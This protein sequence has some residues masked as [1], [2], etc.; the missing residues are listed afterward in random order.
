MPFH[1]AHSTHNTATASVGSHQLQVVPLWSY[2]A[3]VDLDLVCVVVVEDCPA[4]QALTLEKVLRWTLPT[5]CV[6]VWVSL[7]THTIYVFQVAVIPARYVGPALLP[8]VVCVLEVAEVAPVFAAPA[9][10]CGVV[11]MPMDFAD[12]D[13]SMTTAVFC[14]IIVQEV[15]K[16]WP[17]AVTSTVAAPSVV[18]LS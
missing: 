12:L 6:A 7:A 15:G 17:M 5:L 16:H 13:P 3:Q 11:F 10:A 4:M 2:G 14:A 8:T 1:P 18:Q 9:P